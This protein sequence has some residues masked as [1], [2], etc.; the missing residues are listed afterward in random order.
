MPSRWEPLKS[1]WIYVLVTGKSVLE[2]VWDF[3]KRICQ[4]YITKFG[5]FAELIFLVE[6]FHRNFRANKKIPL[7][8]PFYGSW[9]RGIIILR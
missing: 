4:K 9:Y 7:H 3:L 1:L 6:L 8:Q 5:Y 2:N